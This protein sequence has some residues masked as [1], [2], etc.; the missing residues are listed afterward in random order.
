MKTIDDFQKE[1]DEMRSLTIPEKNQL[2]QCECNLIIVSGFPT[3][4]KCGVV[5]LDK[6]VLI[7]SYA[8][9]SRNNESFKKGSYYYIP[10]NRKFHWNSMLNLIMGRK[11]LTNATKWN[12]IVN[13]IKPSKDNFSTIQELRLI[14]KARGFSRYYKYIYNLWFDVKGYRII[15]IKNIQDKLNNQFCQFQLWYRKKYKKRNLTNY[16]L[17]LKYLLKKNNVKNYE[18]ILTPKKTSFMKSLCIL[19]DFHNT[20][21]INS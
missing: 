13:D 11:Q 8:H 16:N 5:Q 18:H 17:L 21:S 19:K 6:V 20:L 14:M 12:E 7:P 10:Y 2:P 4:I 3:C 15:D 9:Q 1:F